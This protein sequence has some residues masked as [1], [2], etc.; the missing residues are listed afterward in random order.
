MDD[1][2]VRYV[3]RQDGFCWAADV[4]EQHR[5]ESQLGFRVDARSESHQVEASHE[6]AWQY[7]LDN[8][9]M[10]ESS[11]RKAVWGECHENFQE[12]L[13]NVESVLADPDVEPQEC[14]WESMKQFD[15]ADSAALDRQVNLYAIDLFLQRDG[16]AYCAFTFDIGWDQ[17]HGLCVVMHRDK[18]LAVN[19]AGDFRF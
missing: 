13:G 12:F 16:I 3:L 17:E 8:R 19:G 14:E 15:W 7:L 6:R 18:V 1:A 2:K 4:Q 10:V 9:T 11:L 5:R